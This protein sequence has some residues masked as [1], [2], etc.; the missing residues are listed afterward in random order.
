MIRRPPRST[1]TDTLFP[2]T[3]LFRSPAGDAAADR[4]GRR[5]G[6]DPA[7]RLLQP[8]AFRCRRH[9]PES[10]ADRPGRGAQPRAGRTDGRVSRRAAL[11]EPA[12]DAG[13]GKLEPDGAARTAVRKIVELGKGF[14]G[15][16]NP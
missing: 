9:G 8:A 14:P 13:R 1:R 16:G 11:P 10:S 3:T 15:G 12:D 4:R 6:T 5:A 7:R 2:D